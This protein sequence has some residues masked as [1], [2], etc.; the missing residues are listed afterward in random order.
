MKNGKIRFGEYLIFKM[1]GPSLI[2]AAN[3]QGMGRH[4]EQEVIE[5]MTNCLKSLSTI[6]GR[7]HYLL[8]NRPCEFDSA[9][10]GQ[11]ASAVFM[12]NSPFQQLFNGMQS[13][14]RMQWKFD[15]IIK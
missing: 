11:L 2:S 6:L 10:F 12:E 7:N 14:I 8:G 13:L 15:C 3:T 4:S 1:I 5:I 9:V